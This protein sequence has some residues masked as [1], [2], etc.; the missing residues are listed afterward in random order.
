MY[1]RNRLWIDLDYLNLFILV[2]FLGIFSNQIKSSAPDP[3]NVPI[4]ARHACVACRK[5][6][7]EYRARNSSWTSIPR[8]IAEPAEI[9][10]GYSIHNELHLDASRKTPVVL[11]VGEPDTT[12]RRA[13]RADLSKLHA[14]AW[15]TGRRTSEIKSAIS[16]PLP[17]FP[18]RI[19]NNNW[20]GSGLIRLNM[21][22]GVSM[23]EAWEADRLHA[24]IRSRRCRIAVIWSKVACLFG[25]I[26]SASSR[27]TIKIKE[28]R[29]I[30]KR[31]RFTMAFDFF[32]LRRNR[33]EEIFNC[34]LLFMNLVLHLTQLGFIVYS[35]LWI[36]WKCFFFFIYLGRREFSDLFRYIAIEF[37]DMFYSIFSANKRL[38]IAISWPFP[39]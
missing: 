31:G 27:S 10:I 29:K 30:R 38:S 16:S 4:M 19:N 2:S 26:A 9:V 21:R 34:D 5:S 7:A 23:F 39:W 6:W 25:K 32:P 24:K 18:S 36:I 12:R 37:Y 22:I 15:T 20:L 8:A 11:Y 35:L 3:S 17:S 14:N 13:R 33:G 28:S 1:R